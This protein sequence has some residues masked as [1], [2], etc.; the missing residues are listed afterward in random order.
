VE[1][2]VVARAAATRHA[3]PCHLGAVEMDSPPVRY[4][5]KHHDSK[6]ACGSAPGRP[7]MEARVSLARF[8]PGSGRRPG[9]WLPLKGQAD[10]IGADP[11]ALGKIWRRDSWQARDASWRGSCAARLQG[12]ARWPGPAAASRAWQACRAPISDWVWMVE[13][14]AGWFPG[15]PGATTAL[16]AEADQAGPGVGSSTA[17]VGHGRP[18]RRSPGAGGDW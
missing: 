9:W 12:R 1:K 10:Q 15:E 17:G 18:D 4:W 7:G 5:T 6:L 16:D 3:G 11:M 14:V 8:R 13:P 2:C